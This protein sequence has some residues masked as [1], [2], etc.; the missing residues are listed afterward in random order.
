MYSNSFWDS[1]AGQQLAANIRTIADSLQ[2]TRRQEVFRYDNSEDLFEDL[3][4]KLAEGYR[5]VNVCRMEDRKLVLI[6]EHDVKEA[7]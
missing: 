6:L 2:K 1:I 7:L 3:A 5:F 4:G